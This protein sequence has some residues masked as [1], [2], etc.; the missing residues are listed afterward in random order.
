M[1]FTAI[2]EKGENGWFV[3]QVEELPAAI[4]QGKTIQELKENLLDAVRLLLDTNKEITE[5]EYYGKTIIKEEL[6][7]I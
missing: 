2:I 1:K 7:L 3:G 5:K 4:S 6:E